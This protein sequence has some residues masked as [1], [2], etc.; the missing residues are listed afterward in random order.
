MIM[1]YGFLNTCSGEINTNQSQAKVVQLIY[2]QYLTGDSLGEISKMLLEKQIPS[3]SDN[4][5]LTRAAIDKL[6]S[7]SKYVSSIISLEQFCTVQIEKANRSN[8]DYDKANTPR[9]T[10]RYSSQNVLS[11]L[12]VCAECGA[13]FRRITRGSGEVVWRCANRVEYGKKICNH[14]PTISEAA[15]IDFLC[16]VLNMEKYDPN[17][18]KESLNAVLIDENTCLIPEFKEILSHS[19]SL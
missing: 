18:V 17:I 15:I 9:K 12:F 10:T 3:P 6:L 8:I 2:Q 11:G 13:N 1:P 19:L 7:N 5:Q 4:V 14:S 16:K